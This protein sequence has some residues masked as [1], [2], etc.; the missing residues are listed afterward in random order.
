VRVLSEKSGVIAKAAR[1]TKGLW[2]RVR[3]VHLLHRH[4][5]P[6]PSQA[7]YR[8]W[9]ETYDAEDNVVAA[10][11]QAIFSAL[12]GET[13]LASKLVVDIGCGT[14]RHWGEVLSLKPRELHGVDSSPEMLA[15]LRA[16]HPDARLYLRSERKIQEFGD[17]SVDLIVS[18]LMMAH[19]REIELELREWA[20]LLK[21]GGEI[22][23]TD[24]HPDAVRSG[25]RTT[26][27]HRGATF[28]IEN[29]LHT[30]K[31]LRSLFQALALDVLDC[32]ERTLDQA[33]RGIYERHNRMDIYRKGFGMPLAIGFRLRRAR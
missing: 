16:R 7:G 29:H 19:V 31:E 15:Q 30:V 12:L 18:A 24:F 14:G 3:S 9:S 22:V 33:V 4:V 20:R 21:P 10:T 1:A 6:L 2:R 27:N 8:L 25:M 26:F 17:A 23:L 32:R 5:R 28:E 13:S 11:E